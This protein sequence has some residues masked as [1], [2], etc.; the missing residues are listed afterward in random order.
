V[1]FRQGYRLYDAP[2]PEDDS[3]AGIGHVLGLDVTTVSVG[4][5]DTPPQSVPEFAACGDD[6]DRTFGYLA[7]E[8]P[9][10]LFFTGMQGDAV[11]DVKTPPSR[12][13][14]R[15]GF[16]VGSSLGEF[17]LRTGFVHV[18]VPFFGAVRQPEI[19]A[20]SQSPEMRPWSIGGTYDRPIPRRI[21]EE[22]GVPRESFGRVKKGSARAI[23]VGPS[24][25]SFMRQRRR[26]RDLP[27]TFLCRVRGKALWWASRAV[28]PHAARFTLANRMAVFLQLCMRRHKNSDRYAVQWG[29]FVLQQ[30]YREQLR[31]RTPEDHRGEN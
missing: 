9:R 29:N 6:M 23:P 30:R 21:V 10:T 31:E 22:K 7:G 11:W 3:G 28:R 16:S 18:P 13:L 17:R 4:D 27:K 5:H 1:T 25:R 24:L 26:L 19:G 14:P 20:L 8:L 2:G 15:D 12:E